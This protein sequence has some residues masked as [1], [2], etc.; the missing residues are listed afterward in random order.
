MQAKTQEGGARRRE[1]GDLGPSG[2]AQALVRLARAAAPLS[3]TLTIRFTMI[4]LGP[5]VLLMVKMCMSRRQNMVKSSERTTRPG[6][7]AA[8]VSLA[9][10]GQGPQCSAPGPAPRLHGERGPRGGG[11]HAW[12]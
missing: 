10:Y 2:C 8:G 9:G 11:R 12:P 1:P 5:S 7:S 6:Y 4:I 3:S